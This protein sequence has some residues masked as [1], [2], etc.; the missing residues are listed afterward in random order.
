MKIEGQE[1]PAREYF[2]PVSSFVKRW[3][4]RMLKGLAVFVLAIV[5]LFLG[6][7]FL[8]SPLLH[9]FSQP[10]VVVNT[11]AGGFNNPYR[12]TYFANGWEVHIS[13]GG[14]LLFWALDYGVVKKDASDVRRAEQALSELDIQSRVR[15]CP[16]ESVL[17]APDETIMLPRLNKKLE[18]PARDFL[19]LQD[20]GDLKALIKL[21]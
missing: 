8:P 18:L 1:I 12:Q 7:R 10:V 3:G 4:K 16:I 11:G 9:L 14:G 15:A 19:C 6:W 20:S 17:D 2:A 21:L 5:V 13:R